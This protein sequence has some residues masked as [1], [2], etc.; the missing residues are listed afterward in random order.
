MIYGAKGRIFSTST[1]TPKDALIPVGSELHRAEQV[2][3]AN[4][5]LRIFGQPG[6]GS[7]LDPHAVLEPG[8]VIDF[9]NGGDISIF[10][11]VTVKGNAYVGPGVRLAGQQTVVEPGAELFSPAQGE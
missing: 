1:P 11:G 6:K 7:N 8:A 2:R 10:A 3:R 9:K 5:G 4:P